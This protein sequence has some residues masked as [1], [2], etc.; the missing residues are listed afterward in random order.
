MKKTEIRN[1]VIA[2]SPNLQ[3]YF[4]T[5]KLSPMDITII[6]TSSDSEKIHNLEGMTILTCSIAADDYDF[7]EFPPLLKIL[8]QHEHEAVL[9]HGDATSHNDAIADEDLVELGGKGSEQT[10]KRQD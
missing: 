8:S 7:Y 4:L 1:S 5:E 3:P 9:G 10:S 2:C 6:P